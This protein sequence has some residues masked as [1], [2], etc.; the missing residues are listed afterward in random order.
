MRNTGY[1]FLIRLHFRRNEAGERFHKKVIRRVLV[2]G[3][4]A[5]NLSPHFLPD[6][7]DLAPHLKFLPGKRDVGARRTNDLKLRQL[8]CLKQSTC[9][10]L[11]VY[12]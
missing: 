10:L 5:P 4:F 8:A 6:I 2:V 11:K 7:N 3:K 12:L 1:S 9:S